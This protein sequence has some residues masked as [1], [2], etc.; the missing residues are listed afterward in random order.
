MKKYRVPECAYC[1]RQS[2]RFIML[3]LT[4]YS[5]SYTTSFRKGLQTPGMFIYNFLAYFFKISGYVDLSLY[6][7]INIQVTSLEF[8]SATS[9]FFV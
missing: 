3:H 2:F 4:H 8:L 1:Y 6:T 9:R 7:E 5:T